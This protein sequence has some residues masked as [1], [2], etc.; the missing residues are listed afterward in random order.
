MK[1]KGFGLLGMANCG[2]VN[3]CRK[4]MAD[5]GFLLKLLC[6]LKSMPSL[7]IRVTAVIKIHS[8]LPGTGDGREQYLH[9]GNLHPEFRQKDGRAE[10]SSSV[11]YFSI[12][13][14]SK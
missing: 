12:A 13:F 1:E 10:I 2:K 6:K 8:S 3:I 7:V 4:L 9:K 11:C 14:I 5:K